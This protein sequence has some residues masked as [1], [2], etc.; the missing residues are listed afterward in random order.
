[1]RKRVLRIPGSKKMTIGQWRL[2][3]PTKMMETMMTM[4]QEYGYLVKVH[5]KKAGAFAGKFLNNPL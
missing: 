3:T 1:M 2:G 5:C 4:I